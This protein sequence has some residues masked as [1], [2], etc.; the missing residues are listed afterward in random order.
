MVHL[1]K[2]KKYTFLSSFQLLVVLIFGLLLVIEWIAPYNFISNF[3]N[4][5][6]TTSFDLSHPTADA[7]IKLWK[8]SLKLFSDNILFGA[9]GGNWKLMLPSVGISSL[10][11]D[12]FNLKFYQ[13]PH[14]APLWMICEYG[15]IGD[16]NLDGQVNILDIVLMA[17]MILSGEYQ[18]LADLNDDGSLNILDIVQL[19]NII[20]YN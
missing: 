5:F 9:G 16:I 2:E 12:A 4:R 1:I 20:L 14:N 13:R 7:R 18:G 17:N 10:P 6:F 19:V 11:F 15:I 3:I 8:E